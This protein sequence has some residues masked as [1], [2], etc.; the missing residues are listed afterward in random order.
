MP[1]TKKI[2]I[3]DDQEMFV[4]MVSNRLSHSGFTV[5][6]ADNGEKGLAVAKKEKPDLILL[7][8]MMPGMDGYTMLLELKKEESIKNTPIIIVTCK[9]D[10]KD[11]FAAV[12]VYDYLIKPFD[13][14]VLLMQIKKLLKI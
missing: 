12:G 2:L 11:L 3:I 8:V 4:K 7:D 5:V 6:S 13:F 14:E 10:M 9:E 1:P